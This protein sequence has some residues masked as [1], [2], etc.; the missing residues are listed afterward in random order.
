M[1]H[2]VVCVEGLGLEKSCDEFNRV[3]NILNFTIRILVSPFG[4]P[5]Y[6]CNKVEISQS[7]CNIVS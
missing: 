2:P 3:G 7:V 4:L 5:V 6:F 1:V